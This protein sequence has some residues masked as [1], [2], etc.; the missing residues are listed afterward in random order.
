MIKHQIRKL[1]NNEIWEKLEVAI[2]EA[3]HSRAGAPGMMGDREFLEALLYLLPTGTP[4]RDLPSELGYWHAVYMRFRRWEARGVWK[5]LW[6]NLQRES[7]LQARRLFLDSTTVRAHQYA[8][9]AQK[10]DSHQA[11]G[12]SGRGMSTKLHAATIDE[13]CAVALHVT[14]GQAHDSRQFEALYER[15]DP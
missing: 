14:A 2:Q 12:R 6:K 5:R 10:N 9:G 13:S 4:W 11:L 8:A 1:I 15:L 3:K 7:F